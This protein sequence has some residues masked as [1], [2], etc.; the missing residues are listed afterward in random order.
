ML[1]SRE[2]MTD[3]PLTSEEAAE[4]R[5]KKVNAWQAQRSAITKTINQLDTAIDCRD[6]RRLRQAR[7]TLTEELALLTKLDAEILDQT[8]EHALETEVLQADDIKERLTL[9]LI[10]IAERIY[11]Q[12]DALIHLTMARVATVV[13]VQSRPDLFQL[14]TLHQALCSYSLATRYWCTLHCWRFSYSFV[15]WYWCLL[16]CQRS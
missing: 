14:Q 16:Y 7:H 4:L 6:T 10:D 3:R 8:D 12:Q 2:R 1:S 11:M 9:A 5:T 15:T 13:I